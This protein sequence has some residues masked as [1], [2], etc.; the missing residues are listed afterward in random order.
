MVDDDQQEIAEPFKRADCFSSV[1]FNVL[2][3]MRKCPAYTS[4]RTTPCQELHGAITVST[5]YDAEGSLGRDQ[6]TDDG[7]H[8]I[9][10]CAAP[11]R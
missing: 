11:V 3:Q 1:L 6:A 4:T 5:H 10:V 7:H 9:E 2:L 8:F